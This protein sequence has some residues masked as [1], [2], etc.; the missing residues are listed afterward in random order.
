MVTFDF[1][2]VATFFSCVQC[3]DIRS[4]A[5]LGQEVFIDQYSFSPNNKAGKPNH[6]HTPRKPNSP[7]HF[8]RISWTRGVYFIDQY[9]FSPNKKPANQTIWIHQLHTPR[10]P[11]SQNHF[12]CISWTRGVYFKKPTNQTIWIHRLHTKRK[13]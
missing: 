12:H 2:K 7:N 10:K 11:N 9:M 4:R 5:Y 13:P 3:L 1:W 6:L 8:H